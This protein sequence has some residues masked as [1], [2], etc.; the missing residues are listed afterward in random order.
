MVWIICAGGSVKNEW[1]AP[2]LFGLSVLTFDPTSSCMWS[3][4]GICRFA[5]AV[6]RISPY[7]V[8]VIA[9]YLVRVK[10]S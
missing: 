1:T 3:D 6:C 9:P 2:L 7:L 5:D 10:Y 8:H 4:Y